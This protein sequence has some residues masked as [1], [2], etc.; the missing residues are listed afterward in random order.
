MRYSFIMFVALG[1]SL[2]LTTAASAVTVNGLIGNLM[3]TGNI[4]NTSLV[5][6]GS[7]PMVNV[8]DDEPYSQAFTSG[9]SF[10]F[11]E[12]N[13]NAPAPLIFNHQNRHEF[14]F[15]DSDVLGATPLAFDSDWSWTVSL[16][17]TIDSALPTSRKSFAFSLYESGTGANFNQDTRINLSTKGLGFG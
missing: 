9:D 2:G 11:A 17:I 14:R 6:N 10:T 5:I 7:M 1:M 8:P 3:E 13:I 15:S 12:T 16:D 4:N